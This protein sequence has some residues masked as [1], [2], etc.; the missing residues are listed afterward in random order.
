[1]DDHPEGIQYSQSPSLCLSHT[2]L[3]WDSLNHDP[4]MTIEDLTWC[5]MRM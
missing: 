4:M 5:F 3:L 1:M 2:H